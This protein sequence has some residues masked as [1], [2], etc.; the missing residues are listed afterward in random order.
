MK[1]LLALLL[2]AGVAF[3][4]ETKRAEIQGR[5]GWAMRQSATRANATEF[6]STS[7][8][9]IFTKEEERWG[10]Q[11]DEIPQAV[12]ALKKALEWSD[13]ARKNKVTHA[14]KEIGDGKSRPTFSF[15]V[16]LGKPTLW[17]SSLDGTARLT[18]E[19]MEAALELLARI[20]ELEVKFKAA[21]PFPGNGKEEEKSLFK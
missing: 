18:P 17:V 9:F 14:E 13:V 6:W 1:T 10:L 3:S 21:K 15:Q 12:A 11:R 8:A 4:E 19:D 16:S 20:K 7:N 5:A 2:F